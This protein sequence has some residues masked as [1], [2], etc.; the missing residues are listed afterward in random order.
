MSNALLLKIFRNGQ[1]VEQKALEQ[2]VIKIGKLRSSHLWLEDDSVAR[3]HA[4]LESSGSEV[5]VIDLGSLGGTFLNGARV[6]KNAAIAHGDALDVGPYRVEV[7]MMH[8]A[9]MAAA[10]FGTAMPMAP[11]ARPVAAAR[12]AGA[13]AL[14]PAIA[15]QPVAKLS[16]APSPGPHSFDPTEVETED[17]MHVAEVVAS[18]RGTVLDAQHVG[19][20]KSRRKSSP[21]FLGAAAALMLSGGALLASEVTQDW[22]AYAAAKTSAIDNGTPIPEAPG[23]GLGGLGLGL[24][25]L[26][27]VPMGM[28]VIRLNDK[29]VSRYRIGE[30]HDAE[31]N[32]DAGA[33]PGDTFPLVSPGAGGHV[34]NFT[35]SMSGAVTV[36]EESI[37]LSELVDSGRAAGNGSGYAYALPAGARCKVSHGEL[38]FH[39]NDVAAG[40]RLA[41]KSEADKPFWVYNA[42]SFAAVGSL[43][44]LTHLIPDEAMAMALDTSDASARYVGYMTQP[45]LEEEEVID[46]DTPE[47][48][49]DAGGQGERHAGTEGAMGDPKKKAAN[50]MY[51]VKGPKTALPQMARDF[52]P[53]MQ[54]RKAGILG[55]LQK[56]SGHFLA[57]PYGGAFAQ[58]T[59]DEDV[60][61]N[62][63]GTEIGASYGVMGLGNV[64]TGR[65]GGG[66][67]EGTVGMG[68]IGLIGHGG[69]GG[70]GGSYGP[71][72]GNGRGTGFT[73]RAKRVPRVRAAKV[74]L[75]GSMDKGI[76]RRIVR[77]HFREVVH[78]YNQGLVR[79]PNLRGRVA[80]QFNIDGRGKVAMA[81][82]ASN[83]TGD[84]NTGRCIAKAV[85]RWSFP[86]PPT[87]GTAM[88]TYPF[89]LSPG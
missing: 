3:M 29:G 66:D 48:A 47:E 44:V 80:I 9:G 85:K 74:K 14:A 69:G 53:D 58:G 27:L 19:Q 39:V 23:T 25:L 72:D 2:D 42:A 36:G 52:D 1:L 54:T 62:M 13:T 8:S 26:S 75:K 34:L 20:V 76:I 10:G 5:R 64:G 31:F 32:T 35:P 60:W 67:G 70:S 49:E 79:D 86:R 68:H 41:G 28:G 57:S 15:P 33:L 24:M 38:T 21:L 45:D 16:G 12:V 82:V 55:E 11:T 63:T 46:E 89:V 4:V 40:K 43:L 83:S 30:A 77:N 6:D 51:A 22:D 65:G 87:G 61:G 17:G 59:D 78:C 18:Y 84:D 37:S 88:V 50:K 73:N 7:E 56:E 71:G 81:A